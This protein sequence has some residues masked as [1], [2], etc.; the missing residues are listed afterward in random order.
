MTCMAHYERGRVRNRDRDALT[1]QCVGNDSDAYRATGC[2][3]P[4][5]SGRWR[6]KGYCASL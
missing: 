2:G 1:A 4:A 5:A 3:D 6:R